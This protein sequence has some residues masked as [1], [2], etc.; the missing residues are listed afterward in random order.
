[1]PSMIAPAAPTLPPPRSGL[2][3]IRSLLPY[4]WPKGDPGAHLRV[5]VAALFLVGAKVATVYV[6][7]VYSHAVDALAPKGAHGM[8]A[9]PVALVIAYALLRVAS[10]GFAELRDAVFASV[11][12]RAVRRVALRTFEHMHRLSL[13]FHLDRQTGGLSRAIDRGTKGIEN[14]LRL[15]VFNILPTFLEVALVTAVLWRLF[16]WRYA[17]V[18]FV[19][20]ALYICFTLGFT[21][22]RV[23]FRRAMNDIES[24]AQT[25]ALDSLLNYETVKYFGNEAHEARRFDDALAR[26]ERAAVRSQV[27]LN[28]LNL[29]QAVIIAIGLALV[30]LMA[31]GEVA[32]GKLTRG[33]VRAR[34]HLPDAALPAAEL[35][36]LRLSR[37]QAGAGG[38]GADV[39]PARHRRGGARPAGRGRA[40]PGAGPRARLR[41]RVRGRAFRL[42]LRPRS[43]EGPV[44]ARAGGALG[45]RSSGRPGPENQRSAGCCSASTT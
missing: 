44:A 4:L 45:S 43:A 24:E 35:P 37:D 21:N 18:T 20:V 30:M 32:S 39:P 7:I 9:V 8:L 34:Q 27:T 26:Y 10:A 17:L 6:P 12:Q 19:A 29:G 40:H 1:M 16:D 2:R 36:R 31:A 22:W 38:H 11:Q 28:M 14:V 23:K 15:A 41:D 33:Q 13:R 25:K 5:V 3:T 42:S